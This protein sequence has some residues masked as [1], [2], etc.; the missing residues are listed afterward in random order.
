MD[1]TH[2]YTG[3]LGANGSMGFELFRMGNSAIATQSEFLDAVRPVLGAV[4]NQI[5]LAQVG[6]NFAS[7]NL[8]ASTG[9]APWVNLYPGQQATMYYT[10]D[11][12]GVLTFGSVQD[13][14]LVSLNSGTSGIPANASYTRIQTFNQPS[15]V[16]EAATGADAATTGGAHYIYEN[17]EYI[18]YGVNRGS[19]HVVVT[20]EGLIYLCV[21]YG[22]ATTWRLGR[23]AIGS[24]VIN[25]MFVGLTNHIYVISG[26]AR[27]VQGKVR[28]AVGDPAPNCIVRVYNRATGSLIGSGLTNATGDY[29]V[30]FAATAGTEV[31]LV[32]LDDD[33]APDFEPVAVDRI[34][35]SDT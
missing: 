4:T 17:G 10:G 34:L 3:S 25:G 12:P 30:R 20:R 1:L 22:S 32:C 8:T 11:G 35:V 6:D 31:Y 14:S 7:R 18:H 29:E 28:N 5:N 16:I 26:E 23:L 33:V 13:S 9:K 2:L 21:L 19:V 24:R 27:I 15:F